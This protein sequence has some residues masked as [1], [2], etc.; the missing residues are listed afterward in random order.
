MSEFLERLLHVL[1]ERSSQK[2]ARVSIGPRIQ[3][4]ERTTPLHYIES[5]DI[6]KILIRLCELVE[7]EG[8]V[9][10]ARGEKSKELN[11][12]ATFK[13]LNPKNCIVTLAERRQEFP[14]CPRQ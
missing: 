8:R 10:D 9:R 12:V 6:N 13:L 1:F 5:D 4:Y 2:H 3:S 7:S 11:D 14:T